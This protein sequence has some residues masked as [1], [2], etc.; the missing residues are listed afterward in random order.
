MIEV[1]L[2]DV[3]NKYDDMTL[4]NYP[5]VSHLQMSSQHLMKLIQI[6]ISIGLPHLQMLSQYVMKLIGMFI[7]ID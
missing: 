3:N 5:H 2:F 7:S 4:I 1:K 6:F